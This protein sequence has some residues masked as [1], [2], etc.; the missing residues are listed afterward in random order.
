MQM[1]MQDGFLESVCMR[2]NAAMQVAIY[3]MREQCYFSY[4][5]SS[6]KDL[7]YIR[8]KPSNRR[9]LENAMTMQGYS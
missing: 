2:E 5:I 7:A 4:H 1:Q 9:Q 8:V 3:L 6:G